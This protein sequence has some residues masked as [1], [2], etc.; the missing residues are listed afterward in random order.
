MHR[1]LKKEGLDFFEDYLEFMLFAGFRFSRV[2]RLLNMQG[3]QLADHFL[4][5]D[6]FMCN[7]LGI[8]NGSQEE[9]RAENGLCRVLKI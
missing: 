1:L 7:R 9:R 8:Y 6:N 3:S 4:T 2:S 5:L